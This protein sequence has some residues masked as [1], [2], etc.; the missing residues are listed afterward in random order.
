MHVI[1]ARA[2]NQAIREQLREISTKQDLP[3]NT[4][5]WFQERCEQQLA[6][7]TDDVLKKKEAYISVAE[8]V[9]H[10]HHPGE[11]PPSL[12]LSGDDDDIYVP[13]NRD[14]ATICPVTRMEMTDPV[15]TCV[16]FGVS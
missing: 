2:Y 1:R 10:V 13:V 8:T 15:K 4:A 7:L 6:T 12:G 5:D 3:E 11:R 16:A 14:I 9:W